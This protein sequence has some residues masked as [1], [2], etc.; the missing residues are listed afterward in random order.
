MAT[1]GARSSDRMF[2][3]LTKA[4]ASLEAEIARMSPTSCKSQHLT[5]HEWLGHWLPKQERE[6]EP[7]KGTGPQ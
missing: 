4:I 7:P 3:A 5:S 1:P 2:G 6:R